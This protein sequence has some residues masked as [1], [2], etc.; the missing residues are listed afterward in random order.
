MK[1]LA[2]LVSLLL[3]TLSL[4]SLLACCSSSNPAKAIEGYWVNVEN[5][6]LFV[7]F[8]NG[9]FSNQYHKDL[10]YSIK[11]SNRL[12]IDLGRFDEVSEWDKDKAQQQDGYWYVSGNTLYLYYSS[13]KP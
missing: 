12:S 5:D 11:G 1:T 7:E 9:F 3:A 13:I 10:P 4:V 6:N 2:K 8:S